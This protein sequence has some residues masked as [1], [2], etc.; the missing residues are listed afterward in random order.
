MRKRVETYFNKPFNSV[1]ETVTVE[2]I[3]AITGEAIGVGI[4]GYD[5]CERKPLTLG[6]LDKG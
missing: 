5:S 1:S 2:P 4:G 6:S 3:L